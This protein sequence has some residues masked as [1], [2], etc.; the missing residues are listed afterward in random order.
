[1]ESWDRGPNARKPTI[2]FVGV[3][4]MGYGLC[5]SLLRHDFPLQVVAHRRRDRVEDLVQRGAAEVS[6]AAALAG[7]VDI[8]MTCLLG[9]DDV[10]A[11]MRGKDGII[12]GGRPD[13]TIFDCTTSDPDLTIELAGLAA[14]R[15]QTL[16]DLPLALGPQE[17]LE[18]KSNLIVGASR[19]EAACYQPLFDAISQRQFFAG[20]VG[21]GHRMKVLNNSL[22]MCQWAAICETFA[23]ARASGADL[24]LLLEIASNGGAAS[25]ALTILGPRLIA[26]DHTALASLAVCSKDT[27][28]YVD[29]ENRLLDR[30][31][32]GPAARTLFDHAI[33]EL[34]PD[35]NCTEAYTALQP[36]K[37]EKPP[38]RG[39]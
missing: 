16:I 5:R 9:P 2:G 11:V 30:T 29:M 15:G 37:T 39:G 20:T 35:A 18:G 26:N 14:A 3:G 10:G 24:E 34:Q 8:L 17:A 23:T 31:F 1:M 7:S 27:G 13:L 21:A 12:A 38:G 33:A 6:D 4:L 36:T 19:D 32:M 22:T 25:R 28:L